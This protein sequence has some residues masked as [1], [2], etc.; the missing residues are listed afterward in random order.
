MKYICDVE[1]FGAIPV[2]KDNPSISP[3]M[4]VNEAALICYRKCGKERESF[5]IELDGK[6]Y[7]S[8]LIFDP[9]FDSEPL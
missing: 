2:E 3:E 8:E 1:G 9:L 6:K 5:V 7:R 4:I